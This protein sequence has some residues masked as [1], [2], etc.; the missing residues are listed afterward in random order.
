MLIYFALES[1]TQKPSSSV[2]LHKIIFVNVL[3]FDLSCWPMDESNMV[4]SPVWI[5]DMHPVV[6]LYASCG[7]IFKHDVPSLKLMGDYKVI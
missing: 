7:I 6:L 4:F 2:I 1:Q 5:D 3:H